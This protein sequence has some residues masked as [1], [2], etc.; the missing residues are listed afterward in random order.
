MKLN[1]N[2]NED[3]RSSIHISVRNLVEFLLRSGDIDDRVG[4][5]DPYKSM[6]AGTRIHRKIQRKM[7]SDYHAEVPLST[8]VDMGDYDIVIEG[9]ADGVF[10][11]T[12]PVEQGLRA[13]PSLTEELELKSNSSE[14]VEQGLVSNLTL[15][16]EMNVDDFEIPYGIDEIKGV[17]LDVQAMEEPIEVH[18]AQAKVYAYIIGLQNRLEELTVQMT[19]CNLDDEDIRRFRYEYSFDELHEW[20]SNLISQYKKWSD[21]QIEWKR[22]SLDSIHAL[23]FPY[24]YRPGQKRLAGDVYHTVQENKILFIQA[25]TGSGKTLATIFP[26]LK[27]V[28]EGLCQR[29]FYLTSKNVTKKVALDTYQLLM[30]KGY[31][32]KTVDITAKDRV[33]PLEER[34]CNPDYCPYAKGHFDRVN[35]AVYDLLTTEDLYTMDRIQEFAESRKVCPFE[36][37]LDLSNWCDNIICDYNYVF[38]PTAYLRRFFAEGERNDSVFLVDE[39]HNLVDRGRR[40]YSASLIKEDCLRIKKILKDKSK[41]TATQLDRV[42]RVLLGW[43]K[44][45]SKILILPEIDEFVFKLMNL[46]S[47]MEKFLEN[48]IPFPERDDV[49]EFYFNLRNFLDRTEELDQRYKI[50]CDYT[51]DGEFRI[52]LFCMDPSRQLQERLDRGVG[53][54]FFSATFLPVRYYKNLLCTEENPYAVYADTVFQPEQSAVL[55]GRDVTTRYTQRSPGM[56][57]T[58]ADY[59]YHMIQGKTGNYMAFFPSYKFLGNV[60]QAFMDSYELTT[61]VIV[62]SSGM[63]EKDRDEFLAAFEEEHEKGLLGFCVMGGLF[64]EGIDLTAERLIGAAIIGTGLP[65]VNPEQNILKDYFDQ[66]EDTESGS[67]GEGFSYAYTYPGMAKVLQAAGRVIRTEDDRGVILLLDQRFLWSEYRRIMPREWSGLHEVT[68]DSVSY[69]LKKFWEEN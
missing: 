35:D 20:F 63:R 53:T 40:M 19:Y 11:R 23:E 2:T 34:Q 25:P 44:N 9:R 33:C 61:D 62:Q 10:Y 30:E 48:R 55:I 49:V 14:N 59:L 47:E 41:K 3:Q 42:N 26:T 32:G 21:F 65:Q 31:R 60:Y 5:R 12:I 28:G 58:Y 8:S 24:D 46:A 50:F 13:N 39:A 43:K 22:E 67:T 1:L 52:N 15:S 16:D 4:S 57:K 17:Y 64:A 69:E 38:D 51:D 7:G 18:L 29:L 68:V 56:Y 36:F 37:S 6:Q 27:A 66:P 45:C 54:I